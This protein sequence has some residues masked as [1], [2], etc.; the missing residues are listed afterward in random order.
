MGST[1]GTTYVLGAG[2][3]RAQTAR[4]GIPMPLATDFFREPYLTAHWHPFPDDEPFGRSALGNLLRQYFPFGNSRAN[5]NIEEVLS[6]LES[7]RSSHPSIEAAR[8]VEKAR[9]QLL[10]YVVDVILFVP[11]PYE[12]SILGGLY[13]H[14]VKSLAPEDAIVTFNW[15]ILLE[16][17]LAR[18]KIGRKLLQTQI[19]RFAPTHDGP[20]RFYTERDGQLIKLH[21]SIDWVFCSDPQC[22]GNHV[23]M[24]VAGSGSAPAEQAEILIFA[25]CRECGGPVDIGILPPQSNKTYS[26][27]RFFRRQASAAAQVLTHSR[28]L[29]VI[30][31]SFPYFDLEARSLFRLMRLEPWEVGQGLT[32]LQNVTLVNPAVDDKGYVEMASELLGLRRNSSHGERPRLLLYSSVEEYLKAER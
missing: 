16:R 10:T 12:T 32:N 18:T 29:I 1:N 2:A 22:P 31:Y 9:R 11:W 28:R 3:S 7:W 24:H 5:I 8:F 4:L 15:D 17:V 27:N 21:G 13:R 26:R 25:R 20:F 6:F 23:P 30:G 19:A 14:I